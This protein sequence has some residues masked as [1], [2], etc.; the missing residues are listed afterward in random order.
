MA[1]GSSLPIPNYVIKKEQPH[2]HRYGKTK[3]QKEHFIAHNLEGDV[4]RKV[5]KGLT[6]ASKRIPYFVHLNSALIGRK[7][8][9]SR[10][11]RWRRKISL[12]E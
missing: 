1:T 4:S 10:W 6:I 12:I 11:A 3:E 9:A 5:L 2:G 8:Y 7:Q